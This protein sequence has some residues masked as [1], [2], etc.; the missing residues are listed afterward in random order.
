MLQLYAALI[1]IALIIFFIVSFFT[2]TPKLPKA[3]L[4]YEEGEGSA[5]AVLPMEITS[6]TQFVE[7]IGGEGLTLV[8]FYATWCGPC[9]VMHPIIEDLA[10][11]RIKNLSV[12]KIDIDFLRSVASLYNVRSVPTLM[13]FRQ[14]N[15]LWRYSG[16]AG[17]SELKSIISHFQ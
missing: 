11:L 6:Q 8:D 14:G 7:T 5:G 12:V 13:L 16:T 15:L 3:S 4:V 10:A 1:G 9:N 17:L 2:R